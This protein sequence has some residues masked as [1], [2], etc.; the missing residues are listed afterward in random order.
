MHVVKI[1]ILARGARVFPFRMC[2]QFRA[3]KLSNERRKSS[4]SIPLS[5]NN[6]MA[7]QFLLIFHLPYEGGMNWKFA[8][9]IVN[10]MQIL[11]L[12]EPHQRQCFF[13]QRRLSTSRG[14]KN[15]HA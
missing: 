9:E 10:R 14:W 11:E 5:E 6:L 13:I 12:P 8:G 7:D 4:L 3:C 2:L 1:C 15:I